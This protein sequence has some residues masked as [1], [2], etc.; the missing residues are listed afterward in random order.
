MLVPRSN[1]VVYL[2]VGPPKTGTTYLQDVLWH[3]RGLLATAGV[4]FPGS[5]RADHF[6]AALDLR[7]I[8]FGGYDNPDTH[9]AWPRLAQRALTAA[10][11]RCVISHEVFAGAD[12]EQIAR[13]ACDLG[14]AE[15]HVVYGARNLARQLPA[16]WQESLKNRR[17]VSYQ[18]FLRRVLR[19]HQISAGSPGFWR[20]QD[21]LGTLGRWSGE[22]PPGRIHVVT[23]PPAGAASDT[24]WLRF[25]EVLDIT[26][27]GYDLD[28][29]RANRS[30]TV[31][32]AEVL[33]RLNLALPQDLPWPAYER[34]VKRRF[35][36]R[37]DTRRKGGRL[38]VPTEHR[39]Q[40][41]ARAERTRVGLRGSGYHIVGDLDDLV[42]AE[43]DF[44]TVAPVSPDMV[45]G[46]AVGLLAEVL[47]E[48]RVRGEQAPREV[49]RRMMG[50]LRRARG[51]S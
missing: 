44:G 29:S 40:V 5:G 38:R 36:G 19:D 7:G 6:R 33:R 24:L 28:V 4:T 27:A 1:P 30:L 31:V 45:T 15:L 11:S 17:T 23:L 41:L 8:A 51:T 32:D 9:G 20:A 49:A 26:A 14:A 34:I 13:L 39:E 42:P 50:H 43:T 21:P 12:E 35:N 46:A 2:H 18:T 3:N 47:T 37:A 22:V 16:V 48:Q 25:C 10:T